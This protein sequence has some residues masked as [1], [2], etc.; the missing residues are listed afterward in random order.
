MENVDENN[1][2]STT[3]H[4]PSSSFASRETS[5]DGT[6]RNRECPLRGQC[7]RRSFIYR[8]L[9][10]LKC[11]SK[12]KSGK[13]VPGM[14]ECLLAIVSL[15]WITAHEMRDKVLRWKC[16]LL[17]I[18]VTKIHNTWVVSFLYSVPFLSSL[19][20]TQALQILSLC[21]AR[22][23]N[24][25]PAQKSRTR[26][27]DL[28][29]VRSIEFIISLDDLSEEIRIVLI[30]EWRISVIYSLLNGPRRNTIFNFR[31]SFRRMFS[32]VPRFPGNAPLMREIC[33]NKSTYSI[34]FSNSVRK[35]LILFAESFGWIHSREIYE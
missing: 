15:V 29:P 1:A 13:D 12:I 31:K 18:L 3:P 24:L 35:N 17:V 8:L 7:R 11:K 14:G 23:P 2:P 16:I 4:S 22:L 34:V 19:L 6:T 28:I 33:H 20:F 21:F 27:W 25:L 32:P 26:F 30:V 9:M 10:C 5:W